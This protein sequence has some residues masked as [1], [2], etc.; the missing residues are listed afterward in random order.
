MQTFQMRLFA[1]FML[2]S[3]YPGTSRRSK[4]SL[5]VFALSLESKKSH[6]PEQVNMECSNTSLSFVLLN[7]SDRYFCTTKCIVMKQGPECNSEKNRSFFIIFHIAFSTL[8]STGNVTDSQYAHL[9]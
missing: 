8:P 3:F 2:S 9:A 7:F 6:Q 5:Q 4:L 1:V